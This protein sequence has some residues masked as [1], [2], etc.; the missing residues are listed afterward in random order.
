MH[1]QWIIDIL[2]DWSVSGAQPFYQHIGQTAFPDRF[3]TDNPESR[4]IH[5][6]PE[7]I[8]CGCQKFGGKLS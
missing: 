6:A 1:C 2:A 4:Q 3:F 8:P 5:I 7:F